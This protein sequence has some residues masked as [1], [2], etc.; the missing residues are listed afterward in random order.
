MFGAYGLATKEQWPP[1]DFLIVGTRRGGTTSLFT[2]LQRH[3]NVMPMWSGAE[4]AK[5]TFFFDE[6]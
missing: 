1:P 4:N 6:N 5:K 2:Y 3:P